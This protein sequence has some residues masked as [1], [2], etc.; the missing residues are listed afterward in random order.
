M[1]ENK[2]KNEQLLLGERRITIKGNPMSDSKAEVK[3]LVLDKSEEQ[4]KDCCNER[5]RW[6]D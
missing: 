1:T 6:N 5:T 3:D 2:E 4:M